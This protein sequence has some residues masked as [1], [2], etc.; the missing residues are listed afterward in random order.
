MGIYIHIPFCKS[1]CAYCDFY[2]GNFSAPQRE[3]YLACLSEHIKR[4]APLTDGFTVDSVFLG[5]GT[6]TVIGGEGIARVGETVSAAFDLSV[7]LEFSVEANPGTV[8]RDDLDVMKKA[9]VNRISF[10][11]QSSHDDE[12]KTL[13]RI[14]SYSQFL[15]AYGDARAAGI[16]N[17][18]VDLMYGLPGQTVDSFALTLERVSALSPEHLSLYGLKIEDNTPFGRMKDSLSLPD[19]DSEYEMYLGAAE[20]LGGAGYRHYEI[21][22]YAKPGRECRHNLKYW[23]ALEYIGFGPSAYSYFGGRRYG[24]AGSLTEYC[25]AVKKGTE[26]IE[27]DE[28]VSQKDREAE[29]IML[30]L[31]L[32]DGI[33]TGEFFRRFGV[34]F[35]QK[36]RDKLKKYISLEVMEKDGDRYYLNDRGMY[37]SN[38]VISDISEF[39]V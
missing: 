32:R 20:K 2:S 26:P 15:S 7:D 39:D 37:V 21:S 22:N 19:E 27:F 31:R 24:Y 16:D 18:N 34:D 5:G 9:G 11:L 13:S 1:K 23:D 35:A 8:T 29:Y 36:Y 6:P 33:G 12:L 10:G 30:R 4:L 25:S 3:E 38:T 28:A 17:I 14:H